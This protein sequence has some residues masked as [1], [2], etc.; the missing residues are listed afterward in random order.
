MYVDELTCSS[1][2]DI[3]TDVLGNKIR[4]DAPKIMSRK[5]WLVSKGV[6]RISFFG[7]SP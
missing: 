4:A 5:V 7:R 2:Q 1:R 6:S 3:F